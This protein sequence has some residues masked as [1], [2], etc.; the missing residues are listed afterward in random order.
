MRRRRP[1]EML[2]RRPSLISFSTDRLLKD[3]AAVTSATLSSF[4][5]PC[6][7]MGVTQTRARVRWDG[8]ERE[9]ADKNAF[10]PTQ[11]GTPKEKSETLQQADIGYALEGNG[12]PRPVRMGA[13]RSVRIGAPRSVRIGA[14]RSVQ[15]DPAQT[16]GPL[17]FGMEH[18]W[19]VRRPPRV[20]RFST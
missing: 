4:G 8:I 13:P 14:P 19:S 10:E 20:G 9:F 5:R 11:G 7:S 18:R 3:I 15:T 2:F 16:Q 6:V 1:T 12:A 17:G